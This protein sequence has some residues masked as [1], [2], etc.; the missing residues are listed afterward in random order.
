MTSL[1]KRLRNIKKYKYFYSSYLPLNIKKLQ[2]MNIFA[3]AGIGNPENF[4]NLLSKYK[5]TVKAIPFLIIM[6]IQKNILNI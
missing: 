2:N 4:F 6:I 3:F 1:K 5:L